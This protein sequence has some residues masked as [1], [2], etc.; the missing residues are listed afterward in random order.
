M[1]RMHIID[2]THPLSSDLAVYPGI[3][4]FRLR[5]EREIRRGESANVSTFEV[6]AHA[7]THLDAPLH[8]LADGASIDQLDL[9]SLIRP[10]QV[11][12]V[13]QGAITPEQ[14]AALGIDRDAVLFRSPLSDQG[15]PQ[16]FDPEFASFTPSAA[17]WLVARG[18][19]LVGLDSW[20]VDPYKDADKGAHHTLLGA[21]VAILEC[22]WLQDVKPGYYTL[23]ALPLRIA[24]AEASPVRAV[25]L[26]DGALSGGGGSGRT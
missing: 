5:W 23:I 7:G 6:G 4:P 1:A 22:L 16:V 9:G 19:R 2:I 15:T 3:L 25:L 8:F 12:Q 21:G 24:G 11:V 10:C 14:L 17:E 20:S 26:P 18:I 13:G